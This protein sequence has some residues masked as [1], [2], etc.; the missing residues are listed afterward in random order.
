MFSLGSKSQSKFYMVHP[1]LV[2][3]A[4]YA[5]TITKADFGIFEGLRTVDQERENIKNKVSFLKDPR[6]CKHCPQKDGFSHAIDAV[7]V[8]NGVWQ[9][10]WPECF[11]IA[12]AF[13]QASIY[14]DIP[15]RWGGVW[16]YHDMRNL[17]VDLNDEV[18]KYRVR[19][20]GKDN[21]DGV[22]YELVEPVVNNTT[23]DNPLVA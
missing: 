13:R 12:E 14:Y 17:S 20:L 6:D 19:H 2:K 21:L 3:I 11:E 5:I 16:D 23:N 9:W 8:I 10:T 1:K 15:I 22:H 7:P 18:E 4:N